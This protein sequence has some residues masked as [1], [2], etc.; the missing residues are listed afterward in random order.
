MVKITAIKKNSPWYDDRANFI[1]E[2]FSIQKG[3]SRYYPESEKAIAFAQKQG[4]NYFVFIDGA[5]SVP[6]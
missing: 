3:T 6:A 1:G 2:K 5:E 4:V